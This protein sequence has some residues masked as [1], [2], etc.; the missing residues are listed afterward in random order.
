MSLCRHRSSM[1][2]VNLPSVDTAIYVVEDTRGR[3]MYVGKTQRRGQ[4]SVAARIA[5]HLSDPEKGATWQSVTIFP[6][7]PETPACEVAR[8][9]GNIGFD[10]RPAMSKQH[11]RDWMN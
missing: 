11:P 5:E 3:V 4:N 8:I 6:L 2:R 7:E 9:E 10:L 1:G